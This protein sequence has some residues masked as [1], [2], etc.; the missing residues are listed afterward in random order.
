MQ[1]ITLKD[2]LEQYHMT[3]IGYPCPFAK[4]MR[5]MKNWEKCSGVMKKIRI[6][7]MPKR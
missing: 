4:R 6:Y 7:Q 5:E 3:P 1:G 2:V